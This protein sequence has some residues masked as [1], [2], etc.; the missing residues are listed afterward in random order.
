MRPLGFYWTRHIGNLCLARSSALNSWGMQRSA[1]AMWW[2]QCVCREALPMAQWWE[3]SNIQIGFST[4]LVLPD[5]DITTA[6]TH[7]LPSYQKPMWVSLLVLY[8]SLS[9][10]WCSSCL[11]FG[12]WESLQ[13]GSCGLLRAL[14]NFRHDRIFW[15][16][17]PL[18][19]LCWN[20]SFFLKA[21]I[22][23]AWR[24]WPCCC[25]SWLHR[26][27][28]AHVLEIMTWYRCLWF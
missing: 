14:S 4:R 25:A 17:V 20:Q 3:S 22:P 15:V 13:T 16:L 8:S 24:E 21:L 23:L 11:R 6:C 28:K 12:Q 19:P 10:F 5:P 7:L 9:L 18:L 1:Q 27:L 2:V 26:A